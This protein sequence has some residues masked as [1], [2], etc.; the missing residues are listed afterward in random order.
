MP[1]LGRS[2]RVP[3]VAKS[4][5]VSQSPARRPGGPAARAHLP[6]NPPVTSHKG[7]AK[8]LS[9]SK[10]SEK[11]FALRVAPHRKPRQQSS[12]GN[13]RKSYTYTEKAKRQ[14]Q[15]KNKNFTHVGV[16]ERGLAQSGTNTGT[17]KK[18]ARI[19][20]YTSSPKKKVR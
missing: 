2:T 11:S 1:N 13:V 9:L 15:L 20:P 8:N 18:S 4:G 12:S 5:G 7:I 17:P 3:K 10:T 19:T 16:A 14:W 6:L